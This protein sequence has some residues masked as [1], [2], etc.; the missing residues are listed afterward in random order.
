MSIVSE[1]PGG[2]GVLARIEGACVS[3]LTAQA[4]LE[5]VAEHLPRAV[6]MDGIFTAATDPDTMLTI[7]A[8]LAH[9]MP[10]SV[11]GPY[12]EHEIEIPDYNKFTDLARG[13]QHV[14]DLHTATGGRPERSARWRMFREHTDFD[15]ELRAAFTANDRGWG[16]L[17]INREGTHGRFTESEVAFVDLVASQVGR[18]LRTSLLTRATD[19]FDGRGPGMIVLD[20]DYRIVSANDEAWSWFT[21]IPRHESLCNGLADERLP[22]EVL[23][24]A[25]VESMRGSRPHLTQAPTRTRVRTHGGGWLAIHASCLTDGNGDTGLIAV[26]VEP[27]NASDMAPLM[28]EAYELTARELDVTRALA[29]GLPTNEIAQ[30]LHLS[31]YTVQDHL[32]RIYEKVGVSSRGELIAKVYADHY[33][34]RLD[35]AIERAEVRIA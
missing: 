5:A 31:R 22:S 34:E 12:W 2:A 23:H 3:G 7:G 28:I 16:I 8:G 18:A 24:A 17:Q 9:G 15:A 27:A 29:R 26:V 1:I 10:D 6:P 32:K 11:C 13:P 19:R 14:A 25:Q 4:L 35:A 33:H 21:E 20:R 30:T